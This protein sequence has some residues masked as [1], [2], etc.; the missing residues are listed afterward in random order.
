MQNNLLNQPSFQLTQQQFAAYLRYPHQNPIPA[1]VKPQRM[2]MYRELFFNNVESFLSSGFPVLRK[3]LTNEQ[4]LE[5][6][7]DFFSR[8]RNET[9]YFSEISEEFL[10]FLQNERNN[11]ADYPF[12]LELAHYEWVEMALS[13]SQAN[14][15]P[16]TEYIED[17]LAQKI[18]ISPLA[19]VL[20]YRYPVHEIHPDFLPTEPPAQATYLVVYRDWDDE[21]RFIQ[22]SPITFR[23]LQI[24]EEKPALTVEE[25]LD[26]MIDEAKHISPELIVSGGLN[27]LQSLFNKSVISIN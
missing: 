20:A 23:L 11:P 14:V 4:W 5:L 17:F 12:L 25:Y 1:N 3:I 2:A 8:H 24:I 22:I 26:K 16:F 13:I 21:V 27:A 18:I 9:P 19:W 15:P 7:E 6:V 10:D